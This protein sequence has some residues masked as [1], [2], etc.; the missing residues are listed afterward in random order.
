M[1][2]GFFG[3][4]LRGLSRG[5]ICYSIGGVWASVLR[6]FGFVLRATDSFRFFSVMM[7]RFY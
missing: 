4:V 7:G 6:C 1:Y 3:F 2:S 5:V